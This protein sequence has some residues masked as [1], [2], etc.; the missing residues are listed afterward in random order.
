M[1]IEERKA[2]ILATFSRGS[3]SKALE[4]SESADFMLMRE[5]IQ[6]NIDNDFIYVDIFNLK[7]VIEY[8]EKD[9]LPR[10]YTDYVFECFKDKTMLKGGDPVAYALAKAKVNS[11]YGMMVQADGYIDNVHLNIPVFSGVTSIQGSDMMLVETA[12]IDKGPQ[13]FDELQQF[14]L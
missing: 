14:T 4:L 6:N 13:I 10:W 5:D 3:I 7:K 1:G 9:Y 11:L 2:S 12:G 8:A